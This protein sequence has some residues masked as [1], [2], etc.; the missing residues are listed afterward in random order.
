M[1]PSPSRLLGG[2]RLA[3]W[4]VR[5]AGLRR[6]LAALGKTLS[7]ASLAPLVV[8]SRPRSWPAPRAV[9]PGGGWD[10]APEP[11]A[12]S[13]AVAHAGAAPEAAG[14]VAATLRLGGAEYTFTVAP[15][16]TLLAAGRAAGAP[17]AFSCGL[18]GCGT[19]RVRLI[20]GE[21]AL[22]DHSLSD[23]ELARGE[24]LTCVGRPRTA[25]VLEGL[26]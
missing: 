13:A 9:A 10:A 8:R 25:V 14:P 5:V 7:G 12:R 24:I 20:A 1:I 19:C 21:V 18:G 15:G 16:Q 23:D 4:A 11:E 22:D 3:R 6:D 2:P 17:L 26:A